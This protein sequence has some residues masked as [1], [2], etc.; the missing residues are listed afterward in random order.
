MLLGEALGWCPGRVGPSIET[1]GGRTYR[2]SSSTDKP[3]SNQRERLASSIILVLV[4][5]VVAS[6]KD[7]IVLRDLCRP[8]DRQAQNI[9]TT[10]FSS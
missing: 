8:A 1:L 5:K 7:T 9:T 4:M 2:R 6:C 10:T 3:R